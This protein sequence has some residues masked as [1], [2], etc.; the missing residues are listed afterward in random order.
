MRRHALEGFASHLP[1]QCGV[2]GL[3][4]P[5][6]LPWRL[7]EAGLHVSP[8]LCYMAEETA[9]G[10]VVSATH[11]SASP[12]GAQGKRGGTWVTNQPGVSPARLEIAH[13]PTFMDSLC[14]LTTPLSPCPPH[15]YPLPDTPSRINCFHSNPCL[16]LLWGKPR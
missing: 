6:D 7:P 3:C 5:P 8:A 14:C 2:G 11:P 15:H 16:R 13:Q 12:E 9:S 1:T 4:V 10:Q